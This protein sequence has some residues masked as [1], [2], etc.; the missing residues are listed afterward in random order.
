M[1]KQIVIGSDE[2]LE[3]EFFDDNNV[4]VD[5]TTR[6]N[7]KIIFFTKNNQKQVI[8]ASVSSIEGHEPIEIDSEAQHVAKIELKGTNTEGFVR[9]E[10]WLQITEEFAAV[11]FPNDTRRVTM[12]A[13]FAFDLVDRII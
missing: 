8:K 13:E 3:I 7:I 2:P 10:V 1:R 6:Q 5:L 4:P 9:G 11:G 12:P